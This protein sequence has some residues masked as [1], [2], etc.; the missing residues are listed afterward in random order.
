MEID[1]TLNILSAEGKE[2]PI[3]VGIDHGGETRMNELSPWTNKKYGGGDGV[4]YVQFIAETLKPFIDSTYRT[5]PNQINT[6]IGG[7]SMGGLISYYAILKYPDVFGKALVFSPS[8]WFSGEVFNFTKEK[9]RSDLKIYLLVGGKE[10][11]SMVP[12]TK[13]IYNLLKKSGAKKEMTYLK[14]EKEGEHNEAFWAEEFPIAIKWLF[15]L[16]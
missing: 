14:I 8:F 5:L 11:I 10:G 15:N 7:S 16:E 13:K 3:V 2:V 1:E 6:S 4:K 12:N 9:F